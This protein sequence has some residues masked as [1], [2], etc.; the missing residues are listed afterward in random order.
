MELKEI[1]ETYQCRGCVCGS[2]FECYEKDRTICTTGGYSSNQEDTLPQNQANAEL[3]VK[4]VNSHP[5]LVEALKESLELTCSLCVR[6]N[7]QHKD[8]N[9]CNDTNDIREALKKAEGGREEKET[10]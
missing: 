4:A 1:I 2:D 7:P 6:L 8:C 5:E 10:S 9:W 3:I